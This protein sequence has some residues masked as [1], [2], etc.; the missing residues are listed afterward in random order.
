MA[1]DV[2]LG[3]ERPAGGHDRPDAELIRLRR[4]GLVLESVS[5][6]WTVAVAAVAIV[7]GVAASSIALIGL[8]LESV[9]E[10]MAAAI[11][12]WQL[13]GGAARE[14][15][16]MRLIGA[17]FVAGAVYL[18]VESIRELAGG[19]HSGPSAVGLAVAVAALLTMPL[20]A[21]IKRR[22]GHAL[23]SYTLLADADETAIAAAAAAVAV[24][25]VGLDRWLGWWWTV[26]A[27]GLVI[28]ALALREGI[29]SWRHSRHQAMVS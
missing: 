28:A 19:E 22:T 8:G 20:L 2:A 18:S 9:I 29:H 23:E 6:T 11:V 14:R 1:R 4:R 17:T 5:M 27:A 26:P 7:A 12:I 15:R 24:I 16:A 25:G 21:H 13:G 10:L 3:P